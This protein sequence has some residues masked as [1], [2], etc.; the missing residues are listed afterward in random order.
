[1]DFDPNNGW[2]IAAALAAIWI[3]EA[4]L[5]G[6]L[7]LLF[8][9]DSDRRTNRGIAEMTLAAFPERRAELEAVIAANTG[10]PRFICPRR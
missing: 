7:I 3:A 10:W 8:K 4:M 9:L 5:F 1:M 2:H 6:V